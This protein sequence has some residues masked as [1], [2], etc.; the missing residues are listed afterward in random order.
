MTSTIE[1]VEDQDADGLQPRAPR[2]PADAGKKNDPEPDVRKGVE[3]VS[4][5]VSEAMPD[6][7]EE[8][9]RG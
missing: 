7:A 6:D 3:P 8:S 1:G 2:H 9:V 5:P 4:E